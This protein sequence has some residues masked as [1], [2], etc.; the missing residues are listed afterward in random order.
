MQYDESTPMYSSKSTVPLP[1]TSI[2]WKSASVIGPRSS[3]I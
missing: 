1:S 3:P 2:I